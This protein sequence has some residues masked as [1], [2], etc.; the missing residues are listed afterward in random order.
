MEFLAITA[1]LT[2]RAAVVSEQILD[3]FQLPSLSLGDET[4]GR[5]TVVKET[6]DPTSPTED[7]DL[8]SSSG[9]A[10][11]DGKGVVYAAA[12]NVTIANVNEITFD[13]L[14]MSDELVAA[15][16]ATDNDWIPAF[17]EARITKDGQDIL[18]L[19]EPI[20]INGAVT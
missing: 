4:S 12:D 14:V 11:T 6:G 15:L 9:V 19:R 18:L 16:A 5:I 1:S 20:T 13:L 3:R 10:L 8:D 17:L 7:V 2:Q